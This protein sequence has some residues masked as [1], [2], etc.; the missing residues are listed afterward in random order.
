M[1]LF[2]A[3]LTRVLGLFPL[4]L[5]NIQG[6]CCD[7]DFDDENR[8]SHSIQQSRKSHVE[9]F[10]S[11][12]NSNVDLHKSSRSQIS[13]LAFEASESESKFVY[14]R[15]L[16][17]IVNLYGNHVTTTR[18]QLNKVWNAIYHFLLHPVIWWKKLYHFN[19]VISSV[20]IWGFNK[21][22]DCCSWLDSPEISSRV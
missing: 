10:C 4:L 17:C 9:L 13:S 7:V 1:K 19:I 2:I 16:L 22:T 6:G 12:F 8:N 14:C 5:N 21:L 11:K 20:I 3:C 18:A 15:E